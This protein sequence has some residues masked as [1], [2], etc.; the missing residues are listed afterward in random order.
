ML[1][2]LEP[3]QVITL[4]DSIVT[5][6]RVSHA[7]WLQESNLLTPS[8]FLVSRSYLSYKSDSYLLCLFSFS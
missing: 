4:A 8:L 3:E 7:V 6:F 1:A 2:T 5:V